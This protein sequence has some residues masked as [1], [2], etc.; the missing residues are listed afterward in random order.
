MASSF[1]PSS[2]AIISVIDS[3]FDSLLGR[4]LRRESVGVERRGDERGGLDGGGRG[5][6]LPRERSVARLG[7]PRERTGG[8]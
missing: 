1:R 3:L 4:Q 8:A 2:V 5:V 6:E 7:T